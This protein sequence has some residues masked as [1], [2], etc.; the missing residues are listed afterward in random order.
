[1]TYKKVIKTETYKLLIIAQTPPPFHGQAIAQKYLVDDDWEWC[2]KYHIRISFSK[3]ISDVSRFSVIKILSALLLD[4]KIIFFVLYHRI[5]FVYY[6]PAGNKKIAFYRDIIIIPIIKLL[7]CK[8]IYHFHSGG[9][10]DL[11]KSLNYVEKKIFKLL[12]FY[13]LTTISLLPSLVSEINFLNSKHNF[14]IPAGIPDNFQDVNKS[15]KSPIKILFLSNLISSKGVYESIC[16]LKQLVDDSYKV[17]FDFVGEWADDK[18]KEKTIDFIKKNNIENYVNFRGTK[19]GS[20]KYQLLGEADIF[21]YPTYYELENQPAVL[22]EAMM[23]KLPIIT[24]NW[25]AIPDIVTDGVE[26][27]LVPVKTPNEIAAKI[28][29]LVK[30]KDL[31]DQMGGKGREKFLREY[32]IEKHLS[33]MEQAFKDLLINAQ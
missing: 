17:E 10:N 23:Y 24:T 1:M 12:Y 6:P 22:L 25:R 31:R 9:I 26:G 29:L 19:I 16:A 30:N 15:K 11:Y 18:F 4:F 5:K 28:E 7:G 3:K 8:I 32:T 21:C 14:I 33:R 2:K 27:F 20:E 13:P